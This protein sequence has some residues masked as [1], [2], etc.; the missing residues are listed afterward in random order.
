MTEWWRPWIPVEIGL[1]PVS[2]QTFDWVM[3]ACVCVCY[4]HIEP[5]SRYC[6][7]NHRWDL[8][9]PSFIFGPHFCLCMCEHY[10]DREIQLS[11]KLVWLIQTHGSLCI[12]WTLLWFFMRWAILWCNSLNYFM[13]FLWCIRKENIN[14]ITYWSKWKK[15]ILVV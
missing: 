10:A 6:F 1:E 11:Q 7:E 9:F 3:W 15:T 5:V 12:L 2:P 4:R 14:G 13:L 8:T